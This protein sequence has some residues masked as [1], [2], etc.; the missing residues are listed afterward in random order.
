MIVP[1]DII[2]IL[3]TQTRE[4]RQEAERQAKSSQYS[5]DYYSMAQV[6]DAVAN[7]ADLADLAVGEEHTA[8]DHD[9]GAHNDDDAHNDGSRGEGSQVD[10]SDG[11]DSQYSEGASYIRSIEESPDIP[12]SKRLAALTQKQRFAECG[13]VYCYELSSEHNSIRLVHQLGLEMLREQSDTLGQFWDAEGVAAGI[14]LRL[15]IVEDISRDLIDIIGSALELDPLFFVQHLTSSGIN[16]AARGCGTGDLFPDPFLHGNLN[17]FSVRWC[18]PVKRVFKSRKSQRQKLSLITSRLVDT[19]ETEKLLGP[20]PASDDLQA[21]EED[22]FSNKSTNTFRDSWYLG[23]PIE[24]VESTKDRGNAKCSI[25]VPTAW[26][27]RVTIH[28]Q[29]RNNMEFGK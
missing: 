15:V 26:E 4:D 29:R 5:T 9:D 7:P 1:I 19:A 27:E 13:T 21:L 20:L 18:R 11:D 10:G 2:Q 6:S 8:Y 22:Q 14:S 28:G 12:I 17:I 3:D 25:K 23:K 24:F 16:K